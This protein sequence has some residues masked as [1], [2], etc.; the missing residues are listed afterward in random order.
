MKNNSLKYHYIFFI[1]AI[2]LVFTLLIIT[3]F[4][5]EVP[6]VNK[7]KP[8]KNSSILSK[9]F[10]VFLGIVL[11]FSIGNSS[12]A[13]LVLRAQNVGVT[14]LAIPL[15]YALFNFVYASF[16]IPL[17]SLSDKIGREKVIILGWVFYGIS[18]LGF[19]VIN[20]SIEVWLMFSFYGIYYATT[21][22]VVKAFVADLVSPENRGKAYGVYNSLIGLITLPASLIAGFLWDRINPSAP[23]LFG[24]GIAF[25]AVICLLVFERVYKIS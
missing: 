18:Y 13:F 3:F 5:K 14:L 15:V 11:L 4:V 17:G 20:K 10:Y 1:T 8:D 24:S 2:P 9:R 25:L 6:F 22:G 12:D 21:E 16:S 23:F 7:N 19:A